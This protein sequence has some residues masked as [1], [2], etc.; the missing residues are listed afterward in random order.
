MRH[1]NGLE[2]DVCIETGTLKQ[3]GDQ[4]P[5]G[6]VTQ[7]ALEVGEV[8]VRRDGPTEV[9]HLATLSATVPNAASRP[10]V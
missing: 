3:A 6:V 9:G 1:E 4:E 10:S 2:F 7:S 8:E 5:V